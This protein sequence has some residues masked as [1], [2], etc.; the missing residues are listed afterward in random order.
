MSRRDLE[1]FGA[2]FDI[3]KGGGIGAGHPDL[4]AE[5]LE[6]GIERGAARRIEMGDH[7][8]EQ[9]HRRKSRHFRDQAGMR[10]H[11][12]DQQR[13]LLAGRGIGG[14]DALGGV[15]TARSVRCGPSSVRPAAA[16]RAR[17]SFSTAR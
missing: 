5:L 17:L 11:E 1:K 13:L 3:R 9:Q 8:V 6:L 4:G 12:A 7:L 16:S 14:G 2:G 15:D 10:Q